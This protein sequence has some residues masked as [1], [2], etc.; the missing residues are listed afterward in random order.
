MEKIKT[1]LKLQWKRI[2]CKHQAWYLTDVGARCYDCK[3]RLSY[4][5]LG[6]ARTVTCNAP[7]CFTHKH[8]ECPVHK[9]S[10]KQVLEAAYPD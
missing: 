3:I 7:N 1:F 5:K 2:R 10:C 9:L 4:K 8:G 6:T